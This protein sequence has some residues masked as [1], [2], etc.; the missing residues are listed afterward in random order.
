MTKNA[1]DYGSITKLETVQSFFAKGIGLL[2]AIEGLNFADIS[3][4]F[5]LY[6]FSQTNK[7]VHE[8]QK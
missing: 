8:V 1:C 3:F 6:L 5:Q 2:A 4:N 7:L